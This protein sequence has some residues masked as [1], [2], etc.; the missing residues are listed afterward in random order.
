[1][2]AQKKPSRHGDFMR[3]LDLDK[4]LGM[5]EERDDPLVIKFIT[6]CDRTLRAEM[7]S[8]F[9]TWSCAEKGAWDNGDWREF[10]T[11]R[12]YSAIEIE[13]FSEYLNLIHE[14]NVKY[15]D[16]YSCSLEF[17]IQKQNGYMD[18]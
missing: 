16:D 10:S 2:R 15:G 4:L 5:I 3:P 1:M 17:L 6:I 12:G 18:L 11:L 7:I 9:E 8:N 13:E 14:L